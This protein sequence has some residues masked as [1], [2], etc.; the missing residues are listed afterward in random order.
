[1]FYWNVFTAVKLLNHNR[2][3]RPWTWILKQLSQLIDKLD[4][5][6]CYFICFL[7]TCSTWS[8]WSRYSNCSQKCNGGRQ[9]RTRRCI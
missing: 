4:E 6:Y 2:T 1:M 9:T 5:F 3:L 8:R 7:K